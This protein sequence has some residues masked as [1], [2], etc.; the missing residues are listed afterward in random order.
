MA[1]DAADQVTGLQA[2]G[3]GEAAIEHPLDAHAGAG[4]GGEHDAEHQRRRPGCA[5][6]GEAEQRIGRAGLQAGAGL[7]A[8]GQQ[9]HDPVDPERVELVGHAE[10]IAHVAGT[11]QRDQQRGVAVTACARGQ[12]FGHRAIPQQLA[13]DE[14]Q[15]GGFVGFIAARAGVLAPGFAQPFEIRRRRPGRI[16][17][18]FARRRRDRGPALAAD[19][20]EQ[21]ALDVQRQQRHTVHAREV[22]DRQVLVAGGVEA[23]DLVPVDGAQELGLTVE[24]AGHPAIQHRLH[25]PRQH[26]QPDHELRAQ[27]VQAG[28]DLQLPTVLFDAVVVFA[29]QHDA[30]AGEAGVPLAGVERFGSAVLWTGPGARCHAAGGQGGGE[31]RTAAGEQQ[32]D[33]GA[34]AARCRWRGGGGSGRGHGYLGARCGCAK[35]N[36]PRAARQ[37]GAGRAGC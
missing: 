23:P 9:L 13:I 22:Q 17:D 29:E 18:P 1:G 14:A 36:R 33:A 3:I 5:V 15:E 7:R 12:G 27:R 6:A 25:P 32:R 31:R 28:D 20:L 21:R 34:R 35:G 8:D 11:E 37:R 19:A 16:A 24:T 2:G 10:A 4:G 26:L 30:R